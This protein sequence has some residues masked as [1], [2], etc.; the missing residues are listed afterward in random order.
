M[1]AA[2]DIFD[3]AADY[4]PA[5]GDEA[6]VGRLPARWAVFLLAGESDV[7]LQLLCARDLRSAVRR[8]LCIAPGAGPSRRADYRAILRRVRWTPCD[9]AFEADLLYLEAARRLFP[10]GYAEL[11]SLRQPWFVHVDPDAR[12]PQYVCTK[13]AARRAGVAIGPFDDRRSAQRLVDLLTDVFDLCRHYHILVQAPHGRACAYKDMG[14]CAA[15]CDG[16]TSMAAYREAVR[17]SIG[18][19]SEPETALRREQDAMRR[20]A[21]ALRFEEAA[22]IRAGI[23]KLGE[24][25]RPPLRCARVL[26]DFRFVSLQAGPCPGTAKIFVV[27]PGVVRAAACLAFP[28]HDADDLAQYC[29]EAVLALAPDFSQAGLYR[30][31]LAARYASDGRPSA[32]VFVPLKEVDGR[33]LV[34]ACRIVSATSERRRG[35]RP[36]LH[37]PSEAP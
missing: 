15:P 34:E 13:D 22:R 26:T 32:G 10:N 18:A 9:S 14:R 33:R 31:A 36:S 27:G 24:L 20:A 17:R 25:V 5:A 7:P 23:E 35:R 1:T 3:H 21:E 30:I 28:P 6:F 2:A 29:R 12:F 4:D 8:R 11:L 19:V 16:S 37:P